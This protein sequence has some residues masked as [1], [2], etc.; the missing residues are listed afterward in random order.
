[1]SSLYDDYFLE[2]ANYAQP[3]YS[4]EEIQAYREQFPKTRF[5]DRLTMQDIRNF[6]KSLSEDLELLRNLLAGPMD[7][8][9]K[10]IGLAMVGMLEERHENDDEEEEEDK[11]KHKYHGGFL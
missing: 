7:E 9:D 5:D 10:K 6:K 3:P 11:F 8:Q 2:S 4:D 1:M